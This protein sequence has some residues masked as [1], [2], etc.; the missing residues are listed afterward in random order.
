MTA[1]VPEQGQGLV[2]VVRGRLDESQLAALRQALGEYAAERTT[3]PAH[4]PDGNTPAEKTR[5]QVWPGPMYGDR[6]PSPW[7]RA[8]G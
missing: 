5:R 8:A 1:V 2:D 7:R 4:T 6:R 3:A